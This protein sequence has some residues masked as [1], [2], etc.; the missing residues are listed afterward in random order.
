MQ[1]LLKTN[2]PNF[3]DLRT[4][5]LNE[6]YRK[7]MEK[8]DIAVEN[9][10]ATQRG[11]KRNASLRGLSSMFKLEIANLM[12]EEIII[13]KELQRREQIVDKD[14]QGIIKKRQKKQEKSARI[15]QEIEKGEE[16]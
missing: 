2:K 7:C 3:K 5:E 14:K 11:E 12:E 1:K 15:K 6:Y 16:K 4:A 8:L 13:L 9:Y 10:H